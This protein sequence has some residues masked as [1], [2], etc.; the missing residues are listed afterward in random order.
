[1]NKKILTALIINIFVVLA[2]A[3]IS[4]SY[5]FY[6]NNP[7]VESGFDSYKF[8]TTDSNILA[9]ISSLVIIPYEIQIL[10]NKRENLPRFAVV[11]KYIGMVSVMLTFFTVMVVLLPKYKAEFLLLGT[12]FY[13]H[14]L[15]PIAALVTV[16]FLETD[17]KIKFGETFLALIPVVIY[18]AVYLTEVLIIGE[19]NGG[20]SDFYTFNSGGHWYIS[21]P[22]MILFTLIIAVVTRLVHNKLTK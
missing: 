3:G 15:G 4:I 1:M 9:A 19:E 5:Y 8:F 12:S 7:L 14:L 20:W 22:V 13:M 21:L 11:F 2:T 18:G 16:L 10:R 17:S 6:S